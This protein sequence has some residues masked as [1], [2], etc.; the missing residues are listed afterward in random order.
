LAEAGYVEGHNLAVEPPWANGRNDRLPALAAE[1]V[2]RR[3]DVIMTAGGP[4]AGLAAKAATATIP[5]VF[6]SGDDP[7]RVGLV[8][9]FNRPGGNLT[10]VTF[11][12]TA[13]EPR[14]LA[15]L[16][17]LVP[18]AALIAVL[19][20]PLLADAEVYLKDV[21]RAAQSL[22]QEIIVLKASN[23]QEI[24]SAIALAVQQR[25][26]GLLVTADPF[27]TNR[28]DQLVAIAARYSIP[29]I[30]FTREFAFAGGLM[31]Y[32]ADFAVMYRQAGDYVVRILKGTRVAD[33]P[34]EQPIKF[35]LVI[36]LKTAKALGLTVPEKLLAL[37]DE[38]ID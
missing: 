13:L 5:I 21:P 35:E 37:S 14:R 7:V 27:F 18:T 31:S 10:G 33:L 11:L 29:A 25:V 36:N 1:L 23:D 15:L 12:A 6:V 30:F 24:E 20:N 4:H 9:S 28:R 34:V 22:G 3:V 38:V 26:G 2:G 8:A 19:I 16:R 17:E 32:G